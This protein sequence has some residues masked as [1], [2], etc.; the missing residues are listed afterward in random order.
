MQLEEAVACAACGLAPARRGKKTCSQSCAYRLFWEGSPRSCPEKTDGAHFYDGEWWI[1]H[2][3]TDGR[4][5]RSRRSLGVEKCCQRCG[6]TFISRHVETRKYCSI[7]CRNLSA[8][9]QTRGVRKP[10]SSP[11]GAVKPQSDGYVMERVAVNDPMMAMSSRYGWCYQHRLVKAREIGRP[12]RSHESVHHVNGIRSDN[13]PENL[14]LRTSAHGDGRVARC[15]DC[16][17]EHIV[18]EALP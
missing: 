6:E 15:A 9:K 11:P 13:R 4:R 18:Y 1:H 17:S 12:L 5:P 7:L 8:G 10:G 2:T 16:G 3:R 14:Q